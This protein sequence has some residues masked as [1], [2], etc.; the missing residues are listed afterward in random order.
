MNELKFR[1]GNE[2]ENRKALQLFN[3]EE[4]NKLRAQEDGQSGFRIRIHFMRIRI[5]GFQN[6]CRSGSAY[7]SGS[8]AKF[9]KVKKDPKNF[10]VLLL[11]RFYK[12]RY[13]KK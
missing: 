4:S 2:S 11:E 8:R 5:Q 7:G 9:L 13:E 6:E 3:E 12:Y 1:V 10:Y